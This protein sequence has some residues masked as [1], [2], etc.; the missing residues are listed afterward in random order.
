METPNNHHGMLR[1]DKK[2]SAAFYL[3][4]TPPLTRCQ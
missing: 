4:A 3:T 2:K 1:P